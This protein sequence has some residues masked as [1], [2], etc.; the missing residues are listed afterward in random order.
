MISIQSHY[1]QRLIFQ[2]R[3]EQVR[4]IYDQIIKVHWDVVLRVANATDLDLDAEHEFLRKVDQTYCTIEATYRELFLPAQAPVI[5]GTPVV[6]PNLAS[7]TRLPK[8]NLRTFD[9]K[10]EDWRSFIEVFSHSIH[11]NATLANIEKFEYLLGC[12]SGEPLNLFKTIPLSNKNYSIAYKALCDRYDD[13]RELATHYWNRLHSL[14]KLKGESATG[15]RSL[16][17]GFK[18]NLEN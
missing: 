2:I 3:H 12:L 18:E 13:K 5:Q 14:P 10:L 15:L 11:N 16:Y 17:E 7:T 4:N 1:V 9:G 6:D 8:R